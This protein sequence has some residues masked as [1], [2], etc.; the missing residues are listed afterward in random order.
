[1]RNVSHIT[2]TQMMAYGVALD[3]GGQRQAL[4][5]CTL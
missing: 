5:K 3:Q 2:M 4:G 1:M